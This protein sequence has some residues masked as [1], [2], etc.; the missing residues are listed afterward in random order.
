MQVFYGIATV[1]SNDSVMKLYLLL[2]ATVTEFLLP[3][4][5]DR[6]LSRGRERVVRVLAIVRHI[7]DIVGN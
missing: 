4:P 1:L 3:Q 5:M 2:V 7:L 6:Y